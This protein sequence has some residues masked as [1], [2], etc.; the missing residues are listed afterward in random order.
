MDTL[1]F[2]IGNKLKEIRSLR[3]LSLDEVTKLT[4][5]SKAMLGQIE[6][7]KSN[8]TVSTLWKIS[9]GL[10]VSFSYFIEEIK[11]EME[12]VYQEEIVPITEEKNAMKLY[13]IYPFDAAKGFEI[14]TIEME[15]G[16]IHTSP[17]HSQGVEEY[18][19]VTQGAITMSVGSQTFLLKQ[20]TS[21]RFIANKEHAYHN[22]E[23]K[24]AV[25]TN[26]VYYS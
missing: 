23:K 8:P 9:T 7:G 6:R 16:C 26:I 1:N 10:K 21:I 4:G 13:P 14:F 3:G 2:T 17:P 24:K 12:V 20:G 18:L 19:I 22:A 25:F 11:E 5:V 15:A